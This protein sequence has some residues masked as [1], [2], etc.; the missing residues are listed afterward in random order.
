LLSLVNGTS[1]FLGSCLIL[2]GYIL[3]NPWSSW[4]I[5]HAQVK[6]PMRV[7][8]D[9]PPIWLIV[10]RD[11][12]GNLRIT[13]DPAA[14]DDVRRAIESG[15]DI[16]VAPDSLVEK[17]SRL[18]RLG[19]VQPH[20]VPLAWRAGDAAAETQPAPRQAIYERQGS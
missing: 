13:V 14:L 6:E 3:M 12:G 15:R 11:E 19:L 2:L 7:T 9:I 18:L 20:L 4:L 17:T 8:T 10:L 16:E 1:L 5:F